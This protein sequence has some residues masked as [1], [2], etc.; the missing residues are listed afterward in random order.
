MY[1]RAQRKADAKSSKDGNL[2]GKLLP[3]FIQDG[4]FLAKRWMQRVKYPRNLVRVHTLGR[5]SGHHCFTCF[6]LIN[7][8]HDNSKQHEIR[9]AKPPTP[10]NQ[11]AASGKLEALKQLAKED[12]AVLS[13]LDENGWGVIH[14]AARGGRTNVI[15]YLIEQGIDLNVRTNNGRGATAL[16]WAEEQHGVDHETVKLLKKAGAKWVS[17]NSPKQ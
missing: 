2:N 9:L 6:Y 13:R 15:S 1:K 7:I 10:A 4:T 5:A 3:F 17:P 8:P 16:W 11:L 14:E 12:P